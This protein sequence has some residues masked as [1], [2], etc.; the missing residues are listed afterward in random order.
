MQRTW[1]GSTVTIAVNLDREW[2]HDINLDAADLGISE[3]TDALYAAADPDRASFNAK[4]GALHMPPY[5]IV[6][7]R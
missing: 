3:V 4:T 7:L 5:S 1:N 2:A 6:V